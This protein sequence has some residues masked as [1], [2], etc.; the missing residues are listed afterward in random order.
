MSLHYEYKDL[1]KIIQTFQS[2]IGLDPAGPFF[3]KQVH[4][5]RLD[6]TDAKFVQVVHTCAGKLG[7]NDSLG[8]ADYWPN[9]GHH[10]PGCEHDELGMCSHGRAYQYFA[11]SLR[12][13]KFKS[14]H[15]NSYDHFLTGACKTNSHSFIG[16]R[17][18]DRM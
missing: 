5:D 13:G 11:E 1:Y 9:G 12:S 17:E 3:F 15:C 8:H 6:K 16:Q 18:I 7:F 2:L 14:W 10:Q 4:R